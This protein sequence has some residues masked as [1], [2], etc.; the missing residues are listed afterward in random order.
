[1]FEHVTWSLNQ[2]KAGALCCL[3]RKQRVLIT[4]AC[5]PKAKLEFTNI[6]NYKWYMHHEKWL[7][8]CVISVILVSMKELTWVFFKHALQ[9]TLGPLIM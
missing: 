8:I 4:A 1:M 5:V 9:N 2:A 7:K 3:I 6:K